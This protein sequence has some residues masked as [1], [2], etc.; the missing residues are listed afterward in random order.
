MFR[1]QASI[2]FGFA[3]L[4]WVYL[5]TS[6][7]ILSIVI[8]CFLTS[9]THYVTKQFLNGRLITD[10]ISGDSIDDDE[11]KKEEEFLSTS[12]CQDDEDD[13]D[14]LITQIGV[15]VQLKKGIIVK[16][17]GLTINWM[18][19]YMDFFTRFVQSTIYLINAIRSLFIPTS[20]TFSSP[21]SH[22]IQS[23]GSNPEKDGATGA[24]DAV[25]PAIT[26]ADMDANEVV[27]K[28]PS[29]LRSLTGGEGE[30]TNSTGYLSTLDAIVKELI[31]DYILIWFQTI[32][33][34]PSTLTS[35][36]FIQDCHLLLSSIFTKIIDDHITHFNFNRIY[37]KFVDVII[38]HLEGGMGEEKKET[39]N[40][41]MRSQTQ[42]FQKTDHDC[43]EPS[44]RY[45][46]WMI[47]HT[48]S[49][50]NQ[51]D[52][53]IVARLDN[54]LDFLLS[55]V[56]PD[57]LI[58]LKF[59]KCDDFQSRDSL[60][61]MVKEILLHGVSIPIVN[62]ISEPS[63]INS[64]IFRIVSK[65][66][67]QKVQVAETRIGD[68]ITNFRHVYWNSGAASLGSSPRSKISKDSPGNTPISRAI[69]EYY[70]VP[71][72]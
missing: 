61:F 42:E 35:C 44:P 38:H 21:Q 29:S 20:T 55:S 23:I 31:N 64:S 19:T 16:R 1:S 15:N 32:H 72:E 66:M 12:S 59:M 37:H 56:A 8:T 69:S 51:I 3:L 25:T 4:L 33:C 10:K 65:S 26:A 45:H 34:N 18:I 57:D 2:I 43:T 11:K 54:L 53:E 68:K 28:L 5:F 58:N 22:E 70:P 60:Y 40:R 67:P 14:D 71:S 50:P 7:L 13:C 27:M 36:D 30:P 49:R 47:N 41:I 48:Q 46:N 39:R 52:E 63:F 17:E 62:I 9:T 24:A 6:S